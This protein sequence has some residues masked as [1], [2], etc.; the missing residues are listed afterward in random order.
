MKL[1]RGYAVFWSGQFEAMERMKERLA[2]MIPLTLFLIFLLLYLNTRSMVKTAIVFLAVPFS[3]VGAIWLLYLLGYHMSIG[4]WVGLIALLGVDAETGI[5]MLTYLDLAYEQETQGRSH[6]H[7]GR[8]AKR[9]SLYGAV[10]RLRP[11]FMTAATMF[12]GFGADHV[13]DGHRLG[14]DET[15]CRADDRR[16]LHVLPVG[17]AGLSGH[18][19]DLEMAFRAE[20]RPRRTAARRARR[21]T[22]ARGGAVDSARRRRRERGLLNAASRLLILGATGSLGRL[23]LRLALDTG[24][25]VTVLVRTPSK[26]PPDAAGRVSVHTGD[27]DGARTA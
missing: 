26:L 14:C 17:T 10:Q 15:H 3:A 23:V 19:P 16:H 24:H 25:D 20:A 27:L 5:F 21:P 12:I 7:A 9:D 8:P 4:V 13:V 1:P 6:A 2:Y 11:K 18:L 22:V